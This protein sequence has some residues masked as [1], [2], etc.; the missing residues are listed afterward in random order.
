[1]GGD[2]VLGQ[3]LRKTWTLGFSMGMAGAVAVGLLATPSLA[4]SDPDVITGVPEV[5]DADILKF[6]KQRV[7]LWGI[8]APEKKQVCQMNGV[9][10]GCYDAAR[11][12]LELLSGRGEVTC[13]L[14][15]AP[16]PFGRRFGVCESGGDDLN[17][18][19]VKSGMALAYED[20]TDAYVAVMGDAIT[21]GVGLWQPGVQ[22]EEPWVFR[23]RETPGG[24]R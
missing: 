6:D 11:R 2:N 22:F 24:F 15:G 4:Q 20:E 9:A 13:Y 16:D 10:W 14:T 17:A 12:Q 7:I 19:M 21:A 3:C 5:Q 23:M 8:D 18:E 1:M